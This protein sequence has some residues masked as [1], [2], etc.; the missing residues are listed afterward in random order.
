MGTYKEF[1]ELRQVHQDI[2]RLC[3][4]KPIEIYGI[5]AK[6]HRSYTPIY[7][8]LNILR[9]MGFIKVIKLRNRRILYHALEIEEQLNTKEAQN[10]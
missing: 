5:M 10:E 9:V 2:Y 3:Y 6:L 7:H 4:E 1:K 8:A